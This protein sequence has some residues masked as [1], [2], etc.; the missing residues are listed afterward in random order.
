GN[1]RN[2]IYWVMVAAGV[3]LSAEEVRADRNDA[4]YLDAVLAVMGS[5]KQS[6]SKVNGVASM[7]AVSKTGKRNTASG[8]SEGGGFDFDRMLDAMEV[9]EY[10]GLSALV[11][12]GNVA[13]NDLPATFADGA[14]FS[15]IGGRASLDGALD[16]ISNAYGGGSYSQSGYSNYW[17]APDWGGGR[18]NGWGGMEDYSHLLPN[19][20][21]LPVSGR[22]TSNFGFRPRFGRM[23]KGVDIAL[24]VGDTVCAAI[25]GTVTR[26]SN[27]PRG[28]GLFVC[29]RHP[30]GLE[31]RYAHLSG[32][33]AY[34]GQIVAAGDP[35]GLGGSTGN[36]TGPHLH[37]EVRVNGEAIDP[38]RMFD[39]NMPA[40][41]YPYR[42]LADL[43]S[44][45]P[46]YASQSMTRMTAS[47]T[48]YTPTSERAT[49]ASVQ[50]VGRGKSTYIVK[51]GDTIN[52]VARKNGISVLSLCRLNM[53]SSTDVLKPGRMLKLR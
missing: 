36:S 53:L 10:V 31:T 41:R 44:R 37:F 39:F 18:Y 46:G 11:E 13:A 25:G 29:V 48:G 28:Y 14:I 12:G 33:I 16:Y 45:N 17:G 52:S 47:A 40:G 7:S 22:I 38:T 23:H 3:C 19:G 4:D 34:P 51:E 2:I 15:A 26:V 30:N 1:L 21:V 24:N 32:T 35:V 43:D 50:A 5:G 20:A 27:D 42:T 6:A 8:K 49:S 9:D